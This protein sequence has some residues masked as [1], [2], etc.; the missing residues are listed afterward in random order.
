M[1]EENDDCLF[2]NLPTFNFDQNPLSQNPKRRRETIPIK[3]AMY[4]ENNRYVNSILSSRESN[5]STYRA[6]QQISTT[7]E[8][9]RAPMT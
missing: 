6:M 1:N 8:T 5:G 2:I 9:G 4:I 3:K 7:A